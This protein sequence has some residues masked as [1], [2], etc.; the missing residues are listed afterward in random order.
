[1]ARNQKQ[2]QEYITRLKNNDATLTELKLDKKQI[3]KQD[4]EILAAALKENQTLQKLDL[5]WN[6]ITAQGAAHLADAL[7]ENQTLQE[8]DLGGNNITDKGA[9]HLAQALKE[10][11]TLQEL[12][13]WK[14][15]ITDEGA[16]HL[17]Q[18]LKENQTLQQLNLWKN[19]ITDEGAAHLAQALKE[20]QTLQVLDLWRN[21]ISGD[22]DR[23]IRQLIKRNK[24]LAQAK[25]KEQE[26]K[27]VAASKVQSS[28]ITQ[29]KPEEEKKA[30]EPI[31]QQTM[32]QLTARLAQLETQNTAQR[33]KTNSTVPLQEHVQTLLN[34]LTAVEAATLKQLSGKEDLSK[35]DPALLQQTA[36]HIAQLEKIKTDLSQQKQLLEEHQDN[37]TFLNPRM[38]NDPKSKAEIAYLENLPRARKDLVTQYQL[39]SFQ[40]LQE[41]FIGIIAANSD[42]TPPIY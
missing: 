26:E 30:F 1:M 31:D 38:D 9:A 2:F 13:L 4:L 16:A 22:L 33:K 14:N 40:R 17:A 3:T 37:F 28:T 34:S 23:Q 36:S 42:D 35:I 10:N 15:N 20:N 7:K 32:A 39:Q 19:N 41:A 18:A 21:I 29:Q 12:N 6:N 27:T 24:E 8:L 5:S 25:A 11:Q